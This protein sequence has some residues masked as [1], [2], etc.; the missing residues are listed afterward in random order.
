ME[1]TDAFQLIDCFH[2]N[3]PVI[4]TWTFVFNEVNP[5]TGYYTML[6]TDN[7]GWG[8]SQFSEGLYRPGGDNA[9]LGERPRYIGER[10]VNHVL[11]RVGE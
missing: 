7:T 4:D 6:A 2:S 3:E 9:H 5:L 10:L 1:H 11:R 8:F